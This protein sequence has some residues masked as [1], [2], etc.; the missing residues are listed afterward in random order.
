MML[1]KRAPRLRSRASQIWQYV[2]PCTRATPATH[3]YCTVCSNSFERI[4]S[5]EKKQTGGGPVLGDETRVITN[6][7]GDRR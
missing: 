1:W 6:G 2:M 4:R 3:A 7:T 5:S